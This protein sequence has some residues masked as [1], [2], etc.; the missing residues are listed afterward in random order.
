[1]TLEN[2]MFMEYLLS[3]LH[4]CFRSHHAII[5]M[6]LVDLCFIYSCINNTEK[7][8]HEK[9]NIQNY[10]PSQL[11][12]HNNGPILQINVS[13]TYIHKTFTCIRQ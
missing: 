6:H 12:D 9:Q 1:M 8:I 7:C 5:L 10:T 11:H 3:L 2:F 4:Q 13:H